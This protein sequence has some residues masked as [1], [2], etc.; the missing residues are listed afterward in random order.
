MMPVCYQLSCV[1][2]CTFL[3]SQFGLSNFYCVGSLTS[4]QFP[5]LT[6]LIHYNH[7]RQ[8]FPVTAATLRDSIKRT[9]CNKQVCNCPSI[10]IVHM[11]FT[12]LYE[13]CPNLSTTI[14]CLKACKLVINVC[15]VNMR[16]LEQVPLLTEQRLAF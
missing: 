3:L 11:K 9:L 15:S 12:T 2:L 1:S 8:P 14:L 10:V 7:F 16:G 6:S 4:K 13:D 5:S